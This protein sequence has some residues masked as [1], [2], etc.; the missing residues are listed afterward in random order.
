MFGLG[1]IV[2]FS[3]RTSGIEE[4]YHSPGKKYSLDPD[5]DSEDSYS[6]EIGLI[7]IRFKGQNISWDMGAFRPLKYWG[8]DFFALP[9]IKATYIY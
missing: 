4:I 6:A 3:K 7:G 1:G 2:S 9:F 8:E 5:D